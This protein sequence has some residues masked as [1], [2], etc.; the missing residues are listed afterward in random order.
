MKVYPL[1]YVDAL[2]LIF[3]IYKIIKEIIKMK[4]D[5][6]SEAVL[7]ALNRFTQ[8]VP[9]ALASAKGNKSRGVKLLSKMRAIISKPVSDD[10]TKDI[11]LVYR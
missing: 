9:V 5:A 4:V 10:L 11:I 3:L 6:N 8:N 1:I 2:L 7:K